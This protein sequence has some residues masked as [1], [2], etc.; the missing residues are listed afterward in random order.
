MAGTPDAVATEIIQ[1]AGGSS[2]TGGATGGG[3][4]ANACA[5]PRLV[6]KKLAAAYRA[7]AAARCGA[8]TYRKS[9]RAKRGRVLSQTPSPGSTELQG[10]QSTWYWDGAVASRRISRRSRSS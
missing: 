9:K 6:G 5:V 7:L 4:T 3:A 8:G 10:R 1:I 2:G